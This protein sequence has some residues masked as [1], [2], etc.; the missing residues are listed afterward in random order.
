MQHVNDNI[1]RDYDEVL[2]KE[3]G[4]PGTE[5]RR[6][7]EVAA[8][9]Y[10]IEQIGEEIRSNAQRIQELSSVIN[11]VLLEA[12]VDSEQSAESLREAYEKVQKEVAKEMVGS[13]DP[14]NCSYVLNLLLDLFKKMDVGL[15]KEVIQRIQNREKDEDYITIDELTNCN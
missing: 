8:Y 11:E 9:L 13:L 7:A 3:F 4:A 1:I 2:D 5:K 15:E 14:D 6:I 12:S 10:Y